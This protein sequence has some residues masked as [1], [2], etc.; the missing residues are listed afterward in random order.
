MDD[1]NVLAQLLWDYSL[2]HHAMVKSDCIIA[3][4]CTREDVIHK[5][6]DLYL[7]GYAPLLVCSGGLSKRAKILWNESEAERFAMIA[8]EMGV[9]KSA[10]IIENKSL[11]TGENVLFTKRELE[12]RGR[13]PS[14]I[15]AV[16]KPYMERRTYATFRQRWP[17]VGVLV[18]SPNVS[19]DG[20]PDEHTTTHELIEQ[21]V[22][23]LQRIKLYGENGYALPQNIPDEVWSAYE[24]LV[25]RGYIRRLAKV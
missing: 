14:R 7:K 13:V 19:F 11:N 9:P 22:G 3:M 2:I 25:E 17:E 23:D 24:I 16:H 1:T 4:G 21:I 5:A 6:A 18:T 15:I 8:L 12:D 10:I 20:Y